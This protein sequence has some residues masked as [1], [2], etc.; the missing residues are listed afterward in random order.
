M[1]TLDAISNLTPPLSDNINRLR[2]RRPRRD[3]PGFYYD[4]E[5]NRYFPLKSPIPGASSRNSSSASTSARKT[6]PKSTEGKYGQQEMAAKVVKMVHMRELYGNSI[7]SN[8]KKMNFQEQY[9]N[10]RTSKPT[11]WKY[12]GTERIADAALEHVYVNIQ[13]RDGLVES[14]LLL[15]GGL[16]NTFSSYIAGCVGEHAGYGTHHMPDV[17]QPLNIENQTS[18]KP[19]RLL[20]NSI[21]A[22]TLMTS[23]V[24]CIKVSRNS[25]HP[26]ATNVDSSVSHALITTL[27]SETSGGSVLSINLSEP[28]EYVPGVDVLGQRIAFISSFPNFTIWTADCNFNG[29]RTVVGTDSGAALVHTES[30][31]R[32]WIFRSKSDVLSLQ[33]DYSGNIVL[34]GLRNGA[35][36]TVDTRQKPQDLHDRHLPKHQIPFPSLKRSESSSVRSKKRENKWFEARGNIQHSRMVFMPSSVSYL[37]ALKLHDQYFLAG[38]MDGTVQLYDH[39]LTQRGAVQMYAGNVNSHTRIQMGVDPSERFVMSGGEDFYLRLW[40]LKSGEMLYEDK[41]MNSVPSVVCWPRGDGGSN[42]QNHFPGAWLGS[43]EGLFYD[44]SARCGDEVDVLQMPDCD[45]CSLLSPSWLID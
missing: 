2:S 14:E 36:L 8:K 28:L 45:G 42:R 7:V 13:T 37:A 23:N 4:A 35:I 34:C 26:E 39:R 32:S 16:N 17:V 11:I 22:S 21:G 18:L 43:R 25:Y 29:N 33:F 10:I 15:T 41:F 9:Q 6:P 5:K 24:S 44:N 1:E 40:R 27:G 19:P 31:R 20:W 3:L 30:G 12:Q 38:S